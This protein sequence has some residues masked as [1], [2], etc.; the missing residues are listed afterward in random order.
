MKRLLLHI[1]LLLLSIVP[2]LA[3]TDVRMRQ[4]YTQ[5]ESDYTIGRIE[6][7]RDSLL[8]HLGS[9]RGQPRQNALRLIALTYLARFDTDQTEHYATLLL[10]ENPYYS[11]S[12]HDP[13]PFVDILNK[14]KSGA[15]I[16]V[17]TASSI[18]ETTVEA[19][20][21]VTIITAEMI[22]NLG[23]NKRLGQ[24][25]ATYVPG[26]SEVYMNTTLN[27]SMHGAYGTTQELILVMENGHRLNSRF[28][29]NCAMDYDIS[30]D[31]IDHI[32]VLRGPA[33]SLYGDV[34]LS[35]VVNII[36]KKGGELDGVKLKYGHGAFSTHKADVSIGTRF[37]D[38][39]IFVWGSFYQS[40][41][42]HRPARDA[43]EYE[44]KFNVPMPND[45]YAYVD[46][47]RDTPTYDLGMTLQYKGLELLI[48]TKNIKKLTQYG[49]YGYYDYDKYRSINGIRPG[50]LTQTSYV[51]LSYTRQMGPATLKGSVYG[52]WHNSEEFIAFTSENTD[53][54]KYRVPKGEYTYIKWSDRTLGGSIQASADYKM[55][56]MKGNLLAGVQFQHFSLTDHNSAYGQDYTGMM[57]PGIDYDYFNKLEH[58]NS[59]SFYTQCKHYFM[60]Q[61]IINAGLRYDLRSR[62]RQNTAKNLSPRLALIYTPREAF[63]IKLSYSKAYV[64]KSYNQRIQ[65]MDLQFA[66]EP[67]YLTAVQ[68]TFMGRITPL[69]LSYDFNLFY[70]KYE[71]LLSFSDLFFTD[72]NTNDGEYKCIGLEASLAYSHRRLTANANFYWQK[73]VKVDNY[74]YSE[75]K[76][77]VLA[78]PKM[79]ANLNIAYKLLDKKKHELK[80][81]GNAKYTG[82][83]TLSKN[84]SSIFKTLLEMKRET[85]EYDLSSTLVVDAGIKYTFNQRLTL[86]LDCEN[87][88]D[89]DHFLARPEFTMFPYYE[90]GRNLMV[91][92][93]YHF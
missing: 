34:A 6:Q 68:L 56:S 57:Q 26:M 64:E 47:Y 83:K 39:D 84:V 60:P 41:G 62:F 80:I 55:G 85:E 37:M 77:A 16:S 92:A 82:I 2:V 45:Y 48:A 54:T 38:A 81:Y 5:A 4:I 79:T 61:L 50:W 63:N 30:T 36:T 8:S 65:E 14:V 17:T 89:T 88:M 24:I 72:K 35:A 74:F 7:A 43:A 21:P 58:E 46:G 15:T 91:A 51:Q 20:A 52:D 42:Q 78:V 93:S 1:I 33:S 71:N 66:A 12:A 49:A 76:N 75:N 28:S 90:R 59:W 11:P 87:L 32:E 70:N 67:Q 13:E 25:L 18:K 31:K 44:E 69:H 40:D 73:A 86:S 10:Q 9:F 27:M 53:T 3:Q 19:P 29:N 22:E 23:Y